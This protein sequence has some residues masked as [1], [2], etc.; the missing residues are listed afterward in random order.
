MTIDNLFQQYVELKKVKWSKHTFDTNMSSYNNHIYPFIGM[1][2]LDTLNYIDYQKLANKLLDLGLSPKTVKNTF[3]IVS[4]IVHFAQK[5][6]FY[7]GTDY[8]QYVELPDFDN[9]KYFTLSVEMQKK[10][11][12]AIM[13]FS[14]PVYKDI[15]LFLLHGRRLNEV[16]DLKW[17]FLDLNQEIMYLPSARNKSRK[18]LSFKMTD[19]QM[20]SLRRFQLDAHDLQGSAFLTGHVFLNPNT[21]KRYNDIKRPWKRLLTKANLP[22]IRIHD[23]RH[24]LGTYLINELNTPIEHVSHLLGHSDI[25]VTQRYV[26]QKPQNAKVCMDN[27]FESV[28]TKGEDYAEKLN[29]AIVLGE[30]VQKTL[31]PSTKFT[32]IKNI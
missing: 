28:K 23:I 2:T 29:Q 17:E 10:Y 5:M 9:K 19:K 25:T 12:H 11:I 31:F 30:F 24:L 3:I 14:E 6:D 20:S 13:N 15:F 18:N 8:V 7:T 22:K 16:L 4:G 21:G 32:Q 27:L 1:S 26:N